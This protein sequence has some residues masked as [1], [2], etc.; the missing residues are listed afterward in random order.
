MVAYCW[1]FVGSVGAGLLIE[2]AYVWIY[3]C[4]FAIDLWSPLVFASAFG[5]LAWHIVG[6]SGCL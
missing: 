1:W 2:V 5:A 3:C 6:V 4:M